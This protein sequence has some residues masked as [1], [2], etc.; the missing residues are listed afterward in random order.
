MK[1][2]FVT[3]TDTNVGKTYISCQIALALKQKHINVLPRKPVESGC[4]LVKGVLLPEDASLL[5][6]ASQTSSS[7]DEVCPYRF[8]Q[9]ISPSVA[10]KLSG[11]SL[12]LEQLK[13]ACLNNISDNDFL[14]VEGAGGFYS[15]ICEDALNA[16]LANELKLPVILITEDRVG[17]VNQVLLTINAIETYKLNLLAIVLS[18]PTINPQIKHANNLSELS[19]LTNYPIFSTPYSQSIPVELSEMLISLT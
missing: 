3:G 10:A 14:L 5:L 7:L 18:S 17:A 19:H 4:K 13:I 2:I 9:A 6:N 11:E 15:P 12:S 16:D 8:A 1:G